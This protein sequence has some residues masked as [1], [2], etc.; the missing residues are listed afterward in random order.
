VRDY[1][2]AKDS[3]HAPVTLGPLALADAR[4]L[5]HFLGRALAEH[6]GREP[7]HGEAAFGRSLAL[8]VFFRVGVLADGIVSSHNEV[9]KLAQVLVY[10]GRVRYQVVQ[11]P[12]SVLQSVLQGVQLALHLGP[13]LV[14]L[15]QVGPQL[16]PSTSLI[17]LRLMRTRLTLKRNTVV[18]IGVCQRS[19]G[20]DNGAS[21]LP[22]TS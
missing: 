15:A 19:V 22:H 3:V 5:V 12:L 18:V 14:Q 21:P 10:E 7:E 20:R 4:Q 11:A 1:P 8:L 16:L 6:L 13:A 17:S 2:K 9:G